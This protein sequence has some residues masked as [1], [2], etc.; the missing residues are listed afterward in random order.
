MNAV[1]PIYVP[2]SKAQNA[3]QFF[4]NSSSSGTS[5]SVCS[6]RTETAGP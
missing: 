5:S 6:E 2:L 4:A 1:Q 3:E